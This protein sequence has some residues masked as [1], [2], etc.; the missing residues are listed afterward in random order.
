MA[1]ARAWVLAAV[2]LVCLLAG[3]TDGWR[4]RRRRRCT[5]YRSALP[6]AV[7]NWDQP[8][9]FQCYGNQAIYRVQSVHCNRAEDRVWRFQCR[10]VPGLSYFNWHYWSPWINTFDNYMNY[11]CPFNGVVTGFKSEHSNSREDRRWKVRCSTK[12]G[13][14]TYNCYSSPYANYWDAAM[15]Y[16][17]PYGY[18]LRGMYGHHDNGREDR[19]YGFRLCRIRL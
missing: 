4:R 15:N 8:F 3:P 9:T 7:N 14:T 13:M 2:L 16:Y 5:Y 6:G 10:S 18:Y 12:W 1:S 17:A 19:R 11:N